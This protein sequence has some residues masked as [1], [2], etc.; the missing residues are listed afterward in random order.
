MD[1][2][3]STDRC[4]ESAGGGAAKWPGTG[5]AVAVGAVGVGNWVNEEI[6][7]DAS[8]VTSAVSQNASEA[9]LA[10]HPGSTRSLHSP[11]PSAPPMPSSLQQEQ[12]ASPMTIEIPC[13][14]CGALIVLLEGRGTGMACSA[15]G[16][17]LLSTSSPENAQ[18]EAQHQHQADG[19]EGFMDGRR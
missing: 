1:S 4:G 9:L 16:E 11:L 19:Y 5:A 13:E 12:A 2:G 7:G 18:T 8:K 17:R 10:A 15:C 6:S 3:T 14:R